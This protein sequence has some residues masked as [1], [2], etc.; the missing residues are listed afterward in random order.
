MHI[1]TVWHENKPFANYYKYRPRFCSEFGFQ[2]FSSRE[3]AETYCAPGGV[4]SG[5]PDFEWHQK[6]IG[7]NDRIRK[8]FARYFHE[9]KDMDGVLY[10][11]QVQQAMAIKTAVGEQVEAP[12]LPRKA[13]L[14]VRR[15][16]RQ[17]VGKRRRNRVLGFQRH[18]FHR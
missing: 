14:R 9:P 2:S 3:V 1:W 15:H 8:T 18:G 16:R 4:E 10:L 5:N 11:S 6:N 7:G 13:V 12:A 17:A